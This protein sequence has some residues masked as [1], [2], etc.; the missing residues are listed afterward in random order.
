MFNNYNRN[1]KINVETS[2]FI[3]ESFA[4]VTMMNQKVE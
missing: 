2:E 4:N 1:D 3:E